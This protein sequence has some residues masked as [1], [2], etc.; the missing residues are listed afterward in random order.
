MSKKFKTE[1]KSLREQIA[2]LARTLA[3]TFVDSH[4]IDSLTTCRLISLYQNLEARPIGKR[5]VLRTVISKTI[6]WALKDDI[7]EAAGSLQTATGLKAGAEAAIHAIRTIFEDPS[8]EGVIL[9]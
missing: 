1:A 7:Q 2:L 6:N 5:E 3:S 9:V 4:S 8:T